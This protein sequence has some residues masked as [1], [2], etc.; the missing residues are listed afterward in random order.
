MTLINLAL[1]LRRLRQFQS[2]LP[3]REWPAQIIWQYGQYLFQSTL[4]WREWHCS[5]YPF[6][7]SIGFQSTLPWRE[8]RKAANRAYYQK[9]A[10]QS[11]LP[12]REWHN[13]QG[14]NGEFLFYFNPHSR[15]GS[16]SRKY[17]SDAYLN[18]AHVYFQFR[19]THQYM[20]FLLSYKSN[21]LFSIINC[22]PPKKIMFICHSQP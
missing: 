15:E 7:S 3:W 19:I 11:T 20:I 5:L 21:I 10:F 22:E 13:N 1:H 6:D 16:D 17:A 2:T 9:R 12:W 14:N 18:L 8:W 4:P